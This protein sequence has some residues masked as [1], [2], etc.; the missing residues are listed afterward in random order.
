MKRSGKR[1]GSHLPVNEENEILKLLEEDMPRLHSSRRDFLKMVG[2]SFASA[3]VMAACKRPVIKAV[4]YTV[5]PPELIPRKPL[6]YASTYFDGHEYCSILVKTLDGR[7]IKIEGNPLSRFN[8]DGTT[9][10]VQAS[11]LS[12]YDDSRLKHP[13][14]NNVKASWEAVDRQVMKDL[15][16]L[17]GKDGETV[18][19]TPTIISPSTKKLIGEFGSSFDKFRWI[20]Y[21]PVSYS[22]IR[23]ANEESFGKPVIPGYNFQNA[24]VVVAL[25]CDFLGTWIAPVHFIPGYISKRKLNDGKR[26]MSFHIQ[27]ESGLSLTGSNADKRI[28]IRPSEEKPLLINLYNKIAEKTGGLTISPADFREDLS[29]LAEKLISAE[30]RSVVVSGTNDREIQIIVNNI[31]Y[32]LGNYEKCID[33]DNPLNLKAGIDRDMETLVADMNQGKI[34]ALLMY[35]VNPVYDYPDSGMFMD[36]LS[37]VPVTINMSVSQNETVAVAKY[38]CPVNHF[39]ESWN[40]AEIIPGQLSLAQPCINPIFN[41]RSFQDSL[42]VWSGRKAGWQQYLTS[43]WERE[44]FPLS[45]IGSFQS[46]WNKTLGEGVFEYNPGG[47]T[48]FTFSSGVLSSLKSEMQDSVNEYEVILAESI[49]MGNGVQANNPWL[50]ELPDPVSRQSWENVASI[51]PA[52]AAQLGISTGAVVKIGEELT[53]PA[54]IQPGQ[55]ERTITV[56]LGYGHVKAGPVAGYGVN[57][58]PFAGYDR[59]N[60]RYS[61]VSAGLTVTGKTQQLALVQLHD[62]QEGRPLV[63]ETTLSRW[64]E[65]PLSGNEAHFEFQTMHKSLYPDAPFDGFHWAMAI[66]LNAC[67]GCNACVIACQAENNS[68]TVGKEEV[69]LNRIMH[70]I[71]IHRYYSEDKNDP[72]VYFQPVFCQHCDDAPCENVCPVSATNHS[73]EG[74][75]QMAYNRCVGTKYCMNNCPYRVRRFNWYRYTNNS[76]FQYNTSSD[77]GKMVL[78]PDV[79]VRERGVVEKCTFCVQRIQAK[80]LEARLENRNLKDF[81]IKPACMQA[82][83]AGAIIF[84]NSNDRNSRVSQLFSDPRRY[85]LLE[86]LHTLPSIG[87]LTKVRNDE[88][89]S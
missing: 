45:G 67:I 89:L 61:Y 88:K 5:Q 15:S 47:K 71:K 80:K 12:L 16:E 50:M 44:Y 33:L 38:E 81:E 26:D 35:E 70:W 57:V 84:G 68:P 77:L 36:G 11:V 29:G 43:G 3:A 53:I 37:K 55:A 8:P 75:N 32:L 82:C 27:I 20:Q 58:F 51:S 2:Y 7:P 62:T 46:F 54:V 60:R 28:K 85:H 66:D 1:K 14:I 72:K 30:G 76:V 4:P 18:L 42:L 87:F 25:N 69:M 24:D 13:W 41:T 48:P 22:A 56:A 9:A 83:P 64:K 73:S 31:N 21:D 39:L 52:D 19:L 65:N 10:R 86:E 79:T 49:A 59:G 78:N 6:Y 74:L 23:E 40:D 63:R 34:K 17:K